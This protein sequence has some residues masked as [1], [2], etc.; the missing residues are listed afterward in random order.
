[1]D[2]NIITQADA[3]A[4]VKAVQEDTADPALI[5]DPKAKTK[6]GLEPEVTFDDAYA[7]LLKIVP[8]PVAGAYA[9]STAAVIAATDLDDAAHDWAMWGIFA[10]YFLMVIAYYAVKKVERWIQWLLALVAF[11]A[12]ATA[13]PGPFTEISG[14]NTVFGTIAV[15][16]A[17][18]MIAIFSP[19]PLKRN[20][21]DSTTNAN[22][23]PSDL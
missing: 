18:T 1:M 19:Q 12:V 17:G 11:V 16:A 23:Q 9:A 7:K 13:T 2:L 14:W 4:A 15:F 6:A 21:A 3:V 22:P 20:Q 10:F 8:V 5:A